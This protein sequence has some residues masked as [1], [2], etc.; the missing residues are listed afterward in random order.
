VRGEKRA[1]AVGVVQVHQRR[2][3]NGGAVV[4][5]RAAADLVHDDLR[6][7]R[8]DARQTG[9]INNHAIDLPVRRR[10]YE[11][12]WRGLVQNGGGLLHL[13]LIKP[14]RVRKR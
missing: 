11:G 8:R 12:R 7:G 4:R 2:P 6:P 14:K 1:R 5:G 9:E 3:R 10:A 13:D